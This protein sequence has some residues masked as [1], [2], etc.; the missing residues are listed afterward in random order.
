[1]N[2]RRLKVAS[3]HSRPSYLAPKSGNARC[4]PKADIPLTCADLRQYRPDL[5][6]DFAHVMRGEVR[7]SLRHARRERQHSAAHGAQNV[8][9]LRSTASASNREP[10]WRATLMLSKISLRMGKPGA[11]N[12]HPSEQFSARSSRCHHAV[13]LA[14]ARGWRCWRWGGPK[15]ECTKWRTSRD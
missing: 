10:R 15:D 3:G 14:Q 4:S 1:M 12:A 8:R 5:G 6:V 9:P 11:L 2:A 13:I 7:Q